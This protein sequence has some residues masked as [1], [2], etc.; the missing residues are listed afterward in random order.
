MVKTAIRCLK[1]RKGASSAAIRKYIETHY[2]VDM[3]YIKPHL[4][5]F[6]NKAVDLG[7]LER[8]SGTGSNGRFKL[9]I[10]S[11]K[12]DMKA[13]IPKK[14]I[15]F[16]KKTKELERP[17]AVN[18]SSK[19]TIEER[20]SI[21]NIRNIIRSRS[22]LKNEGKQEGVRNITLQEGPQKD[23]KKDVKN[24]ND[25]NQLEEDVKKN[26]LVQ[27]DVQAKNIR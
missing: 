18:I 14:D 23:E 2:E 8:T 20:D 7:I 1:D 5:K 10:E 6:L 11:K 21:D 17:K 12:N 24:A 9:V 27:Q 16:G 22:S 3:T 25:Q 13:A 4:R 26:T 19:Y 15:K